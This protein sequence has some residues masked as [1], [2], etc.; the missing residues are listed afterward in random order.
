MPAYDTN[1]H[2]YDEQLR[3][4]LLQFIRLFGGLHVQT[5]KGK[6]G[7]R[8]FRKVPMRL[9]DMNRQVAAIISNNSENTIKAAPF[10]KA[11]TASRTPA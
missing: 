3:R 9:A 4:Y 2:F 1:A 10:I 8:E 7:T 5:G 6:D 11:E